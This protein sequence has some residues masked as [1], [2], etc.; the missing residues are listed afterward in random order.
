[1]AWARDLRPAMALVGCLSA[2]SREPQHAVERGQTACL[3]AGMSACAR[4]RGAEWLHRRAPNS[5]TFVFA[6]LSMRDLGVLP[7][8]ELAEARGSR[9]LPP[10]APLRGRGRRRSTAS[11]HFVPRSRVRA[12]YAGS[13]RRLVRRRSFLGLDGDGDRD[14]RGDSAQRAWEVLEEANSVT[15][16]QID[17]QR[18]IVT[19]VH[20]HSVACFGVCVTCGSC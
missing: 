14:V 20:S 1:M 16:A 9:G 8:L 5:H 3:Q 4:R 19:T 15:V 18:V 11:G 13:R 6:R 7:E 17:V 2:T 10:I 12:R